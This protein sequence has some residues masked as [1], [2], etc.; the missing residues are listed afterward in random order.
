MA[1][2]EKTE[3]PTPRRYEEA[4]SRGQTALSPELGSAVLLLAAFGVLQSTTGDAFYRLAEV[5]RASFRS[6][7]T[8]DL[9]PRMVYTASIQTELLILQILAPLF[10]VLIAGG[11]VLN[12]AQT[13]FLLTLYPLRP[14]L[15]RIN[16]LAGFQRLCSTRSLVEL[17]KT[18][19]KAAVIGL[20]AY[21]SVVDQFPQM[22]LLSRTDLRQAVAA[23]GGAAVSLGTR[24]SLVLLVLGVLDYLYR[25]REYLQGIRMTREELREEM[26]HSE[27]SPEVRARVRRLQRAL[28][29]GRS[30]PKVRQ[31]DV[32]VVNPT[33]YAVALQYRPAEMRAPRV[34][35]KGRGLIAQQIRRIA[36]L[37]GV[38]IVE[39]P[40]LA[41]TLYRTVELGQEVPVDLYQAVAE[42][43]AFVYSLRGGKRG[44]EG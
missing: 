25:R 31:A 19:G 42:L 6:L 18:L 4:R 35:S 26:R 44:R 3:D 40:P 38:P 14:D 15:N 16:P 9:T 43:L 23:L 17:A 10:A 32:V 39:N 21:R 37:A 34:V 8:D 29:Q 2:Q 36:R 41:Q 1:S 11:I 27:G 12:V 7:G 30:L 28:A 22:V 5:M 20:V 13:R 24:V 33:H